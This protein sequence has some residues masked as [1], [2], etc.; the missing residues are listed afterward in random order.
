M[1]TKNTHYMINKFLLSGFLLGGLFINAQTINETYA[2][3]KKD[4]KI[5]INTD[6]PTRTLTIKNSDNNT[7]RPPLRL[8]N[9]PKYD[10]NVNGAMDADLGGN[11]QSNNSYFDY[12]PLVVD[13]VGDVYRGFPITNN[14]S[15]IT[16]TVKNVSGDYIQE[17]D[18]GIDYDKYTV[19]LMSY[20]FKL[21]SVMGKMTMLVSQVSAP[22]KEKGGKYYSRVAP[23]TVKLEGTSGGN[24][25]L[26][27][28][29]DNMNVESFAFNDATG[30]TEKVNGT[31]IITLLIAPKEVVNYIEIEQDLRGSNRGAVSG[32]A[33]TK[34]NRLLNQISQY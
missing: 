31:W 8:V 5:G 30:P 12:R 18:T 20:A 17:F 22:S 10:A 1:P 25:K 32:E 19:T 33:S 24:W 2:K 26:S 28:D 29:Y 9:T 6:V 21:P 15:F 14:T 27:A 23:P 11:R 16:L 3:T 13:N 7:G 4:G 34:L